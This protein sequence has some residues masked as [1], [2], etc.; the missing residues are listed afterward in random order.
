MFFK[1][2]S[3]EDIINDHFDKFV[4]LGT[5]KNSEQAVTAVKGNILDLA[6]LFKNLFDESEEIRDIVE[7][8]CGASRA[9]KKAERE[10]K[11]TG[12]PKQSKK[13]KK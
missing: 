5:F 4:V 11:K 6:M 2:K 13:A 12:A 8:S 3:M 1:K 9:M 7:A 10:A